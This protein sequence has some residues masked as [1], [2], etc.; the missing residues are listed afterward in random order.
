MYSLKQ[1]IS[2][3]LTLALFSQARGKRYVQYQDVQ[4]IYPLHKNAMV[5]RD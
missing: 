5:H 1:S 4:D 3:S 2:C